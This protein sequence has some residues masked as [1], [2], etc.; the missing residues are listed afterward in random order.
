MGKKSRDES[1]RRQI[2]AGRLWLFGLGFL[3]PAYLL[4]LG[5]NRI[6]TLAATQSVAAASLS[7]HHGGTDAQLRHAFAAA[8]MSNPVDA[9]LVTDPAFQHDYQ[10]FVTAGTSEQ[11]KAE[12]A[13]FV[14]ALG[15]AFPSADDNLSVTLDDSTHPA[16]NEATRR[17]SF[18]VIG[19]VVVILLTSQLLLVVGSRLEGTGWS[20]L[21]AAVATPLPI[22]IFPTSAGSRA[23]T[24]VNQA[25]ATAD[26]KFVLLLLAVTP[27]SIL[28]GLWL[29]RRSRV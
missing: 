9:A 1:T 24:Y 17:L 15:E 4:W 27:V 20:G 3:F 8:K 23:H 6:P 22:L 25:A 13:T 5:R 7:T 26:W 12:L 2:L 16:P 11:A 21:I 14:K 19:A 29:T 18:A 28:I 10:I